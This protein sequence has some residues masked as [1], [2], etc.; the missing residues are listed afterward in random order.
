MTSMKIGEIIKPNIKGQIVIPQA[1]R[2]ALGID[3]SMALHIIM[4]G[5]G[6][7]LHP[8]EGVIGLLDKEEPYI[9]VLEKTRGKWRKEVGNDS[10]RRKV[11][12]AASKKRKQ[13]W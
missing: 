6:L 11:E 13:S 4:R 8:I 12:L 9:K 2:K 7:Y 10:Q 1:Y 3:A 5:K